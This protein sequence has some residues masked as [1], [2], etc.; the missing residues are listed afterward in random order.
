MKTA[1]ALRTLQMDYDVMRTA[2][3]QVSDTPD[4]DLTGT[5][6]LELDYKEPLVEYPILV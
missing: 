4:D 2:S 1:S 3:M 5:D 6:T